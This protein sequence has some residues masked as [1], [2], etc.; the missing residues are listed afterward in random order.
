MRRLLVESL[1]SGVKL[2]MI[3]VSDKMV[4][5]QRTIKVLALGES[6]FKA[7]CYLRR[8]QRFF[9][10]ENILSIRVP[11]KKFSRGA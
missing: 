1:A 10:I 11:K 9:K 3:Y 4:V 6:T 5:T 2:E 8:K 7:F